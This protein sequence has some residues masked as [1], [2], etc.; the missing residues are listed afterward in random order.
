M[1]D[2]ELEK[3]PLTSK[4]SITFFIRIVKLTRLPIPPVNPVIN[5]SGIRDKEK[6]ESRKKLG[7]REKSASMLS[8]KNLTPLF[9][10]LFLSIVYFPHPSS[11]LHY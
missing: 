10:D 3:L 11:I 2:R 5:K 9:S 6:I 4:H 7:E 1:R 8:F